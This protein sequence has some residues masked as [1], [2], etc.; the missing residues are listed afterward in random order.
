MVFS[1]IG[2]ILDGDIGGGIKKIGAGIFKWFVAPLNAALD[3]IEMIWDKIKEIL[4]LFGADFETKATIKAKQE[5]EEGKTKETTPMAEGGYLIGEAGI[6]AVVPL[7]DKKE[8]NVDF[9]PLIKVIRDTTTE[10]V[11]AII[12]NKD[13]YMDGNKVGTQLSLSNPRM[14]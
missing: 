9:E 5:E 10:T 7:N 13:V 12:K 1:G 4:N 8:M 3:V 11:N 6:E 14:Q 2:M